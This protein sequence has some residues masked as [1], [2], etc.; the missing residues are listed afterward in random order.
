MPFYSFLSQPNLCIQ[1]FTNSYTAN[2][3][4]PFLIPVS[5]VLTSRTSSTTSVTWTRALTLP[6]LMFI[7]PGR[8]VWTLKRQKR[9]RKELHTH[10]HTHTQKHK[11]RKK[12]WER[13]RQMDCRTDKQSRVR[14]KGTR[15]RERR[16]RW[17]RVS[18]TS[19]SNWIWMSCQPRRVTSGQSNS[20]HKQIHIS[21][22]FLHIYKRRV[23]IYISQPSVKSIYKTN[24]F[25]N[26]T[27]SYTNI[28]HKFSKS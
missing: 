3:F 9:R 7:C 22:L 27:H 1:L 11:E 23:Y 14:Q 13:D 20:G 25:T 26:I 28:R 4:K 10:A 17:W 21:K 12:E 5:A 8:I 6:I 18:S 24:H 16:R 19:S 15:D 2:L